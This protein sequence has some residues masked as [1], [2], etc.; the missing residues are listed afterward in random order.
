MELLGIPR[1]SNKFQGLRGTLRNS[2]ELRGTQRNSEELKRTWRNSEELRGTQ[3]NS[4]E[5]SGSTK[6]PIC[7]DIKEES[8]APPAV[9]YKKVK[10]LVQ[11]APAHLSPLLL[12]W[13]KKQVLWCLVVLGL[14]FHDFSLG[15]DGGARYAQE[16]RLPHSWTFSFYFDTTC[17]R[18]KNLK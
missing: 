4:E 13:T 17:T 14:L 16:V 3:R 6:V 2:E 1:K 11:S 15:G 7:F 9:F 12:V 5:L 18:P 8:S 10:F